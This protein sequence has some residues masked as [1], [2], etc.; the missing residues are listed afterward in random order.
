MSHLLFLQ[1]VSAIF[2]QIFIFSSSDRP[3][4]T[5]K[6]VFDFILKALFVLEIF[7]FLLFFP[8]LSTL[9]R[10]KRANESGIFYFQLLYLDSGFFIRSLPIASL[11]S[12]TRNFG[13]M[14]GL[15]YVS[16]RLLSQWWITQS[17]HLSKD[18][19]PQLVSNPHRSKIRPPMQL[20]YRCMPLHP[21]KLACIN[22]QM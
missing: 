16:V 4:K 13:S 8:F 6:N 12:P 14:L 17:T 7:K 9:S 10:F 3:S 5:M 22:L 21:A 18:C 2:Y 11:F 20:D 15:S 19:Y 1:L